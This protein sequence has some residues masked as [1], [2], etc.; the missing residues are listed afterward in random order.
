MTV[1]GSILIAMLAALG[2]ALTL[3]E[4][5]RVRRAKNAEFICL[6]FDDEPNENKKPDMLII[7]RTDAE[8]EEIIRR[9]CDGEERRVYVKR[10]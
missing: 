1:F 3:L 10:I 6:S 9:V 4:I 2:V 5:V 7:C 8:Q